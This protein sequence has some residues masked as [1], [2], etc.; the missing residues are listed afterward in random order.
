M[1]IRDSYY[2]AHYAEPEFHIRP[3]LEDEY[4]EWWG[5]DAAG[6]YIADTACAG[7]GWAEA[8]FNPRKQ[9][10]MIDEQL[11]AR[12]QLTIADIVRRN[13]MRP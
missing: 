12:H 10:Q 13:L 6:N 5:R 1:C 4:R 2:S 9:I 7:Y 11:V 8:F 3:E